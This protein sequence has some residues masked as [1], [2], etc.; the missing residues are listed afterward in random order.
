MNRARVIEAGKP[1]P[2]TAP[3][4]AIP[5]PELTDREF[6]NFCRLIHRHAGIHLSPQK[7]EL[8]Q[9]RLAKILRSRGLGSY[10]D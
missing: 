3:W 5:S 9:T 2:Q 1:S 4:A 8:L 6:L 7:K 10:Q